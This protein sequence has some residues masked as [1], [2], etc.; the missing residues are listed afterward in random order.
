MKMPPFWTKDVVLP[1]AAWA[2][3]ILVVLNIDLVTIGQETGWFR[4][5]CDVS[6]ESILILVPLHFSLLLVYWVL[7]AGITYLI[8]RSFKWKK[9]KCHAVLYIIA[10]AGIVS[11]AAL[12]EIVNSMFPLCWIFIGKL[13]FGCSVGLL[14][15]EATRR[16]FYRAQA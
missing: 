2:A 14:A 8:H 3:C 4:A 11:L 7:A 13:V 6:S 10:G 5:S 15:A 12:V 16:I 1:G 9:F